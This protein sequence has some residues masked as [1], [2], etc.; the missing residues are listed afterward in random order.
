MLIKSDAFS[1]SPAPKPVTMNDTTL[2]E[3]SYFIE[4]FGSNNSAPAERRCKI[5]LSTSGDQVLSRMYAARGYSLGDSGCSADR[6]TLAVQIDGQAM[7]TLSLH[8]DDGHLA[9]EEQYPEF[10]S[11]LRSRGTRICELG[12]FAIDPAVRSKRVLGAIF[13]MS[14]IAAFRARGATDLIIE[15]NPRH[16]GFY[17]QA[18]HFEQVGEERHCA[19]VGAP[20]VLLHLDNHKMNRLVAELRGRRS[21]SQ[22]DNSFL[23]YCFSADEEEIILAR[24]FENEANA[25]HRRCWAPVPALRR[26]VQIQGGGGAVSTL[27]GGSSV[28]ACPTLHHGQRPDAFNT[29]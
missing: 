7:G 24:F 11:H 10:I 3:F 22:R 2:A 13:H 4:S 9:A 8:M 28:P 19:R 21:T 17:R 27:T 14:W 16:V 1:V 12:K 5:L 15:V 18:L 29:P 20:G 26:R 25:S 23:S 6:T